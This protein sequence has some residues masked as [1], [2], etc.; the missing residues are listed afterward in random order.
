MNLPRPPAGDGVTPPTMIYDPVVATNPYSV[1]VG[2][3]SEAFYWM[4]RA[5]P[6]TK[7]GKSVA[8]FA[9]EAAF[10]NGT[11]V[12]GEEMVFVRI[13]LKAPVRDAGTYKFIHPYGT[14]IIQITAAD[15]AGSNKGIFFT[16]DV[17]LIPRDFTACTNGPIQRFLRQA[18]PAPPAGWVG[19]GATLATV[20]GSPLGF[21]KV[22][23]EGP[24]G[25]DLD[26]RKNNFV[27]TSLF[28]VSGHVSTTIPAALSVERATCSEIGGLEFIDVFATS[29]PTAKVEVTSSF[30][31]TSP[32]VLI[33]DGKGKFY[34]HIPSNG[35]HPT[36]PFPITVTATVMLAGGT[37]PD[38]AFSPTTLV[39]DPKVV[40]T[41]N[42][43]QAEYRVSGGTLTIRAVS[44]DAPTPTL[45]LSGYK[46][47]AGANVNLPDSS[48]TSPLVLSPSTDPPVTIPPPK[49]TVTSTMGGSDTSPVVI[50]P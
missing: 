21:N 50:V 36:G 33:G 22:R 6:N 2:F 25:I 4:A 1:F 41:V 13:R 17:G 19:D 48:G 10:L 23:L 5:F 30:I 46:T 12:P 14:E 43:V 27:E 39:P 45:T 32:S 47:A 49:V 35:T 42:I 37:T 3:G 7:Y 26:G 11:A 29:S 8:T 28:T 16:W 24:A 9:V 18:T 38:P 40:D 31:T 15:I 34:G 44:S 20:T